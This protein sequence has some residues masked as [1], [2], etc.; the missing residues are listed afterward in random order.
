MNTFSQKRK[1]VGPR[2]EISL[3]NMVGT[4]NSHLRPEELDR[5]RVKYPNIHQPAAWL[6]LE[7]GAEKEGYWTSNRF[8]EQVKNAA[9][10]ADVKYRVTHT[11]VWLF[12][13][14]SCHKSMTTLHSNLTKF[15]SKMEVS[16]EGHCL[17]GGGGGGGGG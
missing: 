10:I 5:A 8:M 16:S 15:L 9:D 4:C 14:S 3:K 1:E 13:Q 11:I 12:D 6:L 7:Y 2:S 17:G